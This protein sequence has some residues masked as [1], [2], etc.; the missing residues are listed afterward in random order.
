MAA[1]KLGIAHTW[2]GSG[3]FSRWSARVR[4]RASLSGANRGMICVMAIEGVSA[5]DVCTAERE[6]RMSVLGDAREI[7]GEL[8]R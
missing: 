4:A 3:P 8:Q 2:R 5:S 1:S 7:A 6:A